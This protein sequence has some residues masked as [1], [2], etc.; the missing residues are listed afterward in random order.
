MSSIGVI[1]PCYNYARYLRACVSS[2]LDQPG[3]DVRVLIIDDCSKDETPEVARALAQE[4][5]RIEFRRHETNIGHIG[6]YNEGIEWASGD[7]LLLLSADDLATTGALTRAAEVLDRNPNVCMTHGRFF[8]LPGD[9]QPLPFTPPSHFETTITRGHDFINQLC[10]AGENTVSTPTVIVRTDIQK[11]VGG[12]NVKLPHAGDLEMWLRLAVHG[13]VAKLDVEQAHYRFHATNMH[14]PFFSHPLRDMQQRWLTFHGFF[15]GLNS[16]SLNV[17]HLRQTA[18]RAVARHAF[19]FAANAFDDGHKHQCD[20]LLDFAI[21]LDP[22][23]MISKD[24]KRLLWKRR[25][26]PRTWGVVKPVLRQLRRTT[27]E[28][29]LQP[30]RVST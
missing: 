16:D 27:G 18:A 22:E 4:D 30:A 19:W 15:D 17:P 26:G 5:C 12:Y 23:L 3:V 24:Y 21:Q 28:R 11:K 29:S 20:D 10:R 7:Y 14:I 13:D 2:V 8:R 25:L 6:T 1:I 9:S